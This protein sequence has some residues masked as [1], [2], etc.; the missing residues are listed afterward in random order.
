MR[1]FYSS[2]FDDAIPILRWAVFGIFGRVIS[3]PMGF[4]ILAK[5][6]GGLFFFTESIS[7]VFNIIVLV[8]CY[9]LIG[10]PGSGLA[11]A[12]L[13]V[14]YIILISIVSKKLTGFSWNKQN[15]ILIIASLFLVSLLS[16]IEIL[17]IFEVVK[18]IIGSVLFCVIAYFYIY[19]LLKVSGVSLRKLK[20]T[21]FK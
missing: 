12:L 5:A 14:W 7:G 8:I 4:I 13:Y 20:I 16:I 21:Y 15:S 10:L 1:I 9:K 11:F 2:R 6:K 18:A 17:Q 19:R 3:W